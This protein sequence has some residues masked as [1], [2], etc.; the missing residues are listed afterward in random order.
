MGKIRKRIG[1]DPEHEQWISN[2][3]QFNFSKFVRNKI[4]EEMEENS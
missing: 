3:E 1:I 2:Q 4:E